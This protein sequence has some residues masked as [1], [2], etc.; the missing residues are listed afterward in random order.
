MD[1]TDLAHDSITHDDA[2]TQVNST[3]TSFGHN[4]NI[5]VHDIDNHHKLQPSLV[6]HI[7]DLHP[8]TLDINDSTT[9]TNRME[10]SDS[11]TLYNYRFFNCDSADYNRQPHYC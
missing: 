1:T 8:T 4:T 3:T 6:N 5:P 7:D 2:I 11:N 9:H 10:I